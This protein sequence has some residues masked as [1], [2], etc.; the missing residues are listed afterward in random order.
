MAMFLSQRD[1]L[2]EQE[3]DEEYKEQTPTDD[4]TQYNHV[5]NRVLS[6][7]PPPKPMVS[8]RKGT[9]QHDVSYSLVDLEQCVTPILTLCY[10]L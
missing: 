10:F 8:F 2:T 4:T 7:V 5:P 6:P 9:L 1:K 3:E